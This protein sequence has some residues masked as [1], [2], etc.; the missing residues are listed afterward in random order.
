MKYFLGI[1]IE[2]GGLTADVSLLTAY[3]GFYELVNGKFNKLDELDLKIKPN[4][5][6][7]RVTGESLAI[8]NINLVEH[9][10]IAI[11]EK[12]AGQELYK[13][14]QNWFVFS[15]DKFI[16]V[17]HNVAFDIR[18]ITTTLISMGSWENFVS[19]RV[20]DTCTIAQFQRISG[21]LP[22]NLSCSLGHLAGYYKVQ[23]N[24]KHHEAK[25]DV[26]MTMAVLENLMKTV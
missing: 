19:Y 18:K 11:F 9:D 13:K 25:C 5:G 6:I 16:P 17:G 12:I 26:E 24:G 2:T 23:I 14:L 7:Y 22:E 10:K 4:D 21:K 20:M 8:N 15:K 3:F 1:D